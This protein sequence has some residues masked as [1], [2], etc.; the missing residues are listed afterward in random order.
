MRTSCCLNLPPPTSNIPI[1]PPHHVSLVKNKG[2]W[3]RQ[4]VM[5]GVA[6][7]C[8]IIGLEVNNNLLDNNYEGE[9]LAYNEVVSQNSSSSLVYYVS[10][11]KWSQKSACPS[12]RGNSFETVVP[13]N[14]PRPAARRRYELVGSTTKD[15]PPLSSLQESIKHGNTKG[16]CF[17][18]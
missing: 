4:C 6:S 8:T 15:A 9:A 10:G 2:Y 17:S 16:S 5:I 13:E 3:R 12:W 14:L 1:K 18:L 7:Y 11:S